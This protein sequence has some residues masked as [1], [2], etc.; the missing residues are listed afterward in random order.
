MTVQLIDLVGTLTGGGMGQTRPPN[1]IVMSNLSR[2][3]AETGA[4]GHF[5]L[6]YVAAGK[7]LYRYGGKTFPVAAGQFLAVPPGMAGEV[8][9]A[10]QSGAASGMCLG[11]KCLDTQSAPM[12]APLLFA[13]SCSTLGQML[14]RSHRQMATGPSPRARVAEH[15]AAG[16]ARH[17]ETLME[18]ALGHLSALAASRPVTRYD[19][20]RKLT[21]ARAYLHDVDDRPVALGEVAAAAGVSQFH[22]LRS[23]RACFGL[24]P[25]TYHRRIRLEAARAAVERAEMTCTQAALRYGF[26][27]GASF[28]HAHR[29]AFGT[30]PTRKV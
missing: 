10:H 16:T 18:E 15:L 11:L 22:L 21:L 14:A 24:P 28:S 23:F 6:K 27:D 30:A 29:R 7:E 2:G 12:E 20:L 8:E 1:V 25:S 13:A 5:M 9:I 17:F 19:L 3:A 4:R 26:A